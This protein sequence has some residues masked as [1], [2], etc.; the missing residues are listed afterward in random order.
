MQQTKS[1]F[2]FTAIPERSFR[3]EDEELASPETGPLGSYS[4]VV[5]CGGGSFR[6]IRLFCDACQKFISRGG[7]LRKWAL[8]PS[9]GAGFLVGE[10]R[11]VIQA[12]MT[13]AAA[14]Y[15]RSSGPM[16]SGMGGW[17]IVGM[18]GWDEDWVGCIWVCLWGMF[19]G[20]WM[21]CLRGW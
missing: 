1:Q 13:M 18:D 2:R 12:L 10:A 5:V 3:I 15:I 20:V 17:C 8:L 11:L 6:C 14:P 4:R 7:A 21:D 16:P 9:G 19:F